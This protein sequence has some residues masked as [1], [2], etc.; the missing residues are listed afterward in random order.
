MYIHIYL[1]NLIHLYYY[2]HVYR[3][4]KVQLAIR[5]SSV[6]GEIKIPLKRKAQKTSV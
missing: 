3:L 1:G 4:T 5:I 2:I 6:F